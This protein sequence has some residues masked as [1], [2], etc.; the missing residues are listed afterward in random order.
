[1][2]PLV[3]GGEQPIAPPVGEP[4][5]P[6][7]GPAPIGPIGEVVGPLDTS[8]FEEVARALWLGIRKVVA[9]TAQLAR[10][11]G[12]RDPD[13]NDIIPVSSEM[14]SLAKQ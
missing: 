10:S 7:R 6:P 12:M 8:R 2:P 5:I 4:P 3:P 14:L 13:T 11:L 1:M 9:E